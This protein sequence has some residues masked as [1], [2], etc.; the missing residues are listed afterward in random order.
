MNIGN[1]MYELATKLF[2]ICRSITGDGVRKT[3]QIVQSYIPIEI[4]EIPTATPV[5]DWEVPKEWN[6]VDAWVKDPSGKKNN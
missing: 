3:L 5:F 1:K 4:N 2:P 6:I